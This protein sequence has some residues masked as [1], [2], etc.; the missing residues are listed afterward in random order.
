MLSAEEECPGI[1]VHRQ[2]PLVWPEFTSGFHG[3]QR[4]TMNERVETVHTRA[5]FIKEPVDLI[6]ISQIR[7]DGKGLAIVLRYQ[8]TGFFRLDVI[9]QVVDY[10]GVGAVGGSRR[11]IARPIPRDPRQ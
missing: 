2:I 4:G 3:R 7:L 9:V 10:N 8:V 1:D 5:D 6:R 11:A